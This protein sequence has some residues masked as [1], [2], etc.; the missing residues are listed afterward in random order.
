MSKRTR[1]RVAEEVLESF[2]PDSRW[3]D[4]FA[5]ADNEKVEDAPYEED[6]GTFWS[7]SEEEDMFRSLDDRYEGN[8][9]CIEDIDSDYDNASYE[10]ETPFKFRRGTAQNPID[11]TQS[12]VIDLTEA[13][14]EKRNFID[15]TK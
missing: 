14:H 13:E 8:S 1:E 2:D 3:A 9:F 7:G 6:L 15:L 11:L 5:R 10:E 12:T 4:D